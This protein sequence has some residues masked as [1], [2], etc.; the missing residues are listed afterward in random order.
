MVVLT[1]L[2]LIIL[3]TIFPFSGT[4]YSHILTTKLHGTLCLILG[5]ILF[6][7]L[8]RHMPQ[9]LSLV[10][11]IVNWNVSG[12]RERNGYEIDFFRMGN[13]RGSGLRF[14]CHIFHFQAISLVLW[15]IVFK[16]T[17]WQ[18]P[19]ARDYYCGSGVSDKGVGMK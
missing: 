3:G 19:L 2:W 1:K 18:D 7:N 6:I 4:T 5:S 11:L 17:R 13:R 8:A 10:E 14:F 15:T 16:I 9:G 12:L